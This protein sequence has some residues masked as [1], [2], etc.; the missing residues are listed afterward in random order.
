[1]NQVSRSWLRMAGFA[2][3]ALPLN[4]L[5]VI[6][7]V[8]L[9]PLYADHQGLG[10]AAV[11]GIFLI[12]KLFDI[13]AAPIWGTVMDNYKTPWGR[14]RPWLVLAVPILMTSVYMVSNPPESAGLR[15]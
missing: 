14:R 11:G 2:L 5:V 7:F 9:P 10:T 3:P 12:T 8:F 13:I 15:C 1:M 4:S 6:V